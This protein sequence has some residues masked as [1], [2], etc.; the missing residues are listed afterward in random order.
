MHYVMVR[1]SHQI[2]RPYGIAKQSD[3]YLTPADPN[4]TFDPRDAL[5]SGQGSS[6]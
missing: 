4:M 1:G 6:H 2:W 5:R 3:P